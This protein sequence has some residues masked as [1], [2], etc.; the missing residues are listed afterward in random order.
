MTISNAVKI[1]VSKEMV[2]QLFTKTNHSTQCV[3]GLPPGYKCIGVI[4][5]PINAIFQFCLVNDDANE[6]QCLELFAPEYINMGKSLDESQVQKAIIRICGLD[7]DNIDDA[8]VTKKIMGRK[9]MEEFGLKEEYEDSEP[10]P[11]SQD[12]V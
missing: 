9:L 6:A 3:K 11:E 2:E 12:D 4:Q 5:N 7:R 10:E 1:E 8:D